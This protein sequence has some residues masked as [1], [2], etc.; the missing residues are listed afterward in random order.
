MIA[1]PV[2]Y[3]I[4]LNSPPGPAHHLRVAGQ[5]MP[6]HYGPCLWV[7][8]FGGIWAT[9]VGAGLYLY[10]KRHPNSFFTDFDVDYDIYEGE[11]RK[12]LILET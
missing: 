1:V 9:V 6:I 5:R 11:R 7:N 12:T 8:L 4:I 2:L 3:C 10:H